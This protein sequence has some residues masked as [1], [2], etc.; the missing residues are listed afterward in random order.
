M[1]IYIIDVDKKGL[2]KLIL[3]PT[4]HE[5]NYFRFMKL[6]PI[7]WIFLKIKLFVTGHWLSCLQNWGCLSQFCVNDE[8]MSC[9]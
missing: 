7:F 3:A 6:F 2:I 5:G 9:P 1:Y 8:L 4:C